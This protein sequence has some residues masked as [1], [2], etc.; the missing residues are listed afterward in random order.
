[1]ALSIRCFVVLLVALVASS[2]GSFLK[3]LENSIISQKSISASII[4]DTL[5]MKIQDTLHVPDFPLIDINTSLSTSELIVSAST[6]VVNQT[7]NVTFAFMYS[8][9]TDEKL[10]AAISFEASGSFA[11]LFKLIRFDSPPS[12]LEGVQG[13]ESVRVSVSTFDFTYPRN[14]PVGV[15]LQGTASVTSGSLL[16][17]AQRLQP[18][19]KKLGPVI[20]TLFIPAF[21]SDPSNVTFSVV[22][23]A[24][25]PLGKNL[26]AEGFTLTASALSETVVIDTPLELAITQGKQTLDIDVR[27][28]FLAEQK[29]V[30]LNGSLSTAWKQPLGLHWMNVEEVRASFHIETGSVYARM[31]GQALFSFAKGKTADIVLDVGVPGSTDL[32]QIFFEVEIPYVA[33]DNTAAVVQAVTGTST[34]PPQ[35]KGL[36]QSKTETSTLVVTTYAKDGFQAG[37]TYLLNLTIVEGGDLFKAAQAFKKNPETF[38][39]QTQVFVPVFTNALH[40]TATFSELGAFPIIGKLLCNGFDM[41]LNLD[42]SN[43]PAT[44]ITMS[45]GLQISFN[46]T[47]VLAFNVSG[48][49]SV[50][51]LQATL[52]GKLA[53]PW[54]GALGLNWLTVTSATSQLVLGGSSVFDSLTFTGV[55]ALTFVPSSAPTLTIDVTGATA[56]DVLVSLQNVPI[57]T[58]TLGLMYA[59]L[60]GSYNIPSGLAALDPHGTAAISISTYAGQVQQGVTLTADVTLKNSGAGVYAAASTLQ[61]PSSVTYDL[62]LNVPVFSGAPQDITFDLKETGGF[63][64]ANNLQCN[65]YTVDVHYASGAST[66]FLST[67]LSVSVKKDPNPVEF[68][69]QGQF[70]QAASTVSMKGNLMSSWPHPF[71]QKWL[72]LTTLTGS[73][74]LATGPSAPD[75]QSLALSGSGNFQ[76]S[77]VTA[78]GSISVSF[79]DD[80]AEASLD[81]STNNVFA[82]EAIYEGITQGHISKWMK[83][84]VADSDMSLSFSIDTSSGVTLDTQGYVEGEVLKELE[85]TSYWWKGANFDH[86]TFDLSLN[87]PVFSSDPLNVDL[88]LSLQN[89]SIPVTKT[90]TFNDITFGLDVGEDFS[91][92]L[93]VKALGKFKN[94]PPL[95]FE[96]EGKF[97][98]DLTV[99]LMG[100]M[101]GTWEDPFGIKNFD[102]SN[103]IAEF[104]LNPT[105]I[106]ADVGIGFILDIGDT[107]IQFDANL[108]APEWENIF[109]RGSI[110]K[111][112]GHHLDVKGVAKEWNKDNPKKVSTALIPDGWGLDKA[113]FWLA[114]AD[115]SFGYITYQ[116][117]FGV[118]ANITI[119]DMNVDVGL[120]CTDGAGFTCNFIFDIGIDKQAFSD[121]IKKHLPSPEYD[122][123]RSGVRP[124][125]DV[126][127]VHSVALTNWSQK[128]VSQDN[129]PHWAISLTALGKEHNLSFNVKQYELSNSFGTFFKKWLQ[130]VF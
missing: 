68:H 52:N 79:S 99:S 48:L 82:L 121:M 64:L 93:A 92:S 128:K 127:S 87:F 28:E 41:E 112:K 17:A 69:M 117:G 21:S 96:L 85:K 46:K 67:D 89:Y 40:L 18:S 130:H 88:S 57:D 44:T 124:A 22:E 62:M 66:I 95:E 118:D 38:I 24:E 83:N 53:A 12:F 111:T 43:L 2:H 10:E 108:A 61:N 30:V 27:G 107:E 32:S 76:F 123:V 70:Q 31:S 110:Q 86:S 45:S 63:K 15:Q 104:G 125:V 47:D 58:I 60:T 55:G 120:N 54:K 42:F 5:W 114:T 91:I 105:T 94:N 109:A 34:T 39:Y 73:L 71:G 115:G 8:S 35:L 90:V 102:V 14:L 37:L 100:E 19:L 113:S 25:F 59:D 65:G 122:D 77:N 49:F 16:S 74:V 116:E 50:Q 84:V 103:V 56:Q 126:F 11:S 7:L 129:N 81:A 26:Q 78:T 20:S 36:T 80:F 4:G 29:F 23:T 101:L 6:Q 33:G 51:T 119:L 9:I 97:D 3:D 1:M 72:T 106:I 75:V 13:S 98:A